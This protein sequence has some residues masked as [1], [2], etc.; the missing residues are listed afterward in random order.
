M[1]ETPS[2]KARLRARVS[3]LVQCVGFRYF[4]K[5][6]AERLGITGYA[7]NLM[8]GSVEVVAEGDKQRLLI[9]FDELKKGPSLSHVESVQPQWEEAEGKFTFFRVMQ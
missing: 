6:H 2:A 9:F 8:D 5:R 1:N 4:C 7:K 3:G